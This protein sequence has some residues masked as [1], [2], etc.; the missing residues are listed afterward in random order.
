MKHVL[1]LC[2]QACVAVIRM[3]FRKCSTC[4]AFTLLNH[5]RDVVCAC[6]TCV[7]FIWM[8]TETNA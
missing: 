1:V 7:A 8:G 4:C 6:R 3:A 2:M 5:I